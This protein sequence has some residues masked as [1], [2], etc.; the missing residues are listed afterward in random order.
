MGWRRGAYVISGIAA[1]GLLTQLAWWV[2]DPK[3]DLHQHTVDRL[4]R[5]LNRT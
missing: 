1:T 5:L 2:L 4:V 3:G